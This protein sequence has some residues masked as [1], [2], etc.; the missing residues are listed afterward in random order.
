MKAAL[1]FAAAQ[2]KRSFRDPLSLFFM[3]LFPLIFLFVF[4]T[5]FGGDGATSFKVAMFDRANNEFSKNFVKELGENKT[6]EISDDV[7]DIDQ[8]KAK[9]SRGELDSIIELPKG[10][11]E[12]KGGVECADPSVARGN[13]DCLPSGELITYYNEG[14]PEAGQTVGSIMESI[15]G[16]IG[17]SMTGYH[18]PFT[19]KAE[20]T[21]TASLS[22]FDYTFAGLLSF[23][24]MSMGIYVLSMYLPSDKKTG[25]LRRVKATPFRP[26]QLV[27]GMSLQ[28]ILLSLVSVTVMIITALLVFNFD[29][30]GSWLVL[31]AFSTLSVA[32]FCGIGMII[33]AWAR[34][35]TQASMFAQVVAMPMMFLSGVFFPRF[36]MPDWLQGA[37]SWIPMTPVGEGVRMITTE[38]ASLITVM[39]QIGLIALWGV[40]AYLVAFKVFRW[41]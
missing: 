3:A 39:P 9:M 10:F 7:T 29:M 2:L 31:G 26:W 14:S 4:G 28:Y 24:L 40:V 6:L 8:A 30:R 5:I 18:A 27:V 35:D 11:G 32:M 20:S 22:Q 33:A 17:S 37:T 21:A 34:N 23:T 16:E 15:L 19:V 36:L 1:T 13:V 38:G 41:E 25:L 12:V